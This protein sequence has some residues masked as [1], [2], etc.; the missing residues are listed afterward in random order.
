MNVEKY[1]KLIK[2]SQRYSDVCSDNIDIANIKYRCSCCDNTIEI[3]KG[4]YQRNEEIKCYSKYDDI[5]YLEPYSKVVDKSWRHYLYV[6]TYIICYLNRTV[7]YDENLWLYIYKEISNKFKYCIDKR[8]W[9]DLSVSLAAGC[10]KI[11]HNET[12][13]DDLSGTI[14][15]HWKKYK[16][17]AKTSRSLKLS[18]DKEK[19]DDDRLIGCTDGLLRHR[20]LECLTMK[21]WFKEIFPYCKTKDEVIEKMTEKIGSP[22]TISSYKKYKAELF[23]N[24]NKEHKEHKERNDKNKEHI[25]SEKQMDKEQKKLAAVAQEVYKKK[26]DYGDK[27]QK[28]TEGNI[29]KWYKRHWKKVEDYIKL[30]SFDYQ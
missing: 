11:F 5:G 12:N 2:N 27:W 1:I 19:Y 14:L 22:F 3:E 20:K 16:R 23:P 18:F 25:K 8:E 24:I 9:L 29:V 4:I 13:D 15:K 30:L 17:P 10:E 21:Q 7:E 6:N 26:M 28:Y